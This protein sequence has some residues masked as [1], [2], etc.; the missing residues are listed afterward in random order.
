MFL[1]IVV[2]NLFITQ[3]FAISN[4][5][6]AY[7]K[8][9]KSV[10]WY[11]SFINQM[12]AEKKYYT[13]VYWFKDYIGK[14]RPFSKELDTSL[15]RVILAI[16]ASQFEYL[17]SRYLENSNSATV[18]YIYA[19]KLMKRNRYKEALDQV[20]RIGPRHMLMPFIYHMKG[21]LYSAQ[22]QYDRARINFED[23]VRSSDVSKPREKL[24]KEYCIAGLARNTYGSRNLEKSES[25][26]LDV[27]KSSRVWP[28]ILYEEAWNSYYR[29]KYN[30]TLGKLVTYKAPVLDHMFGPKI[31]V[32]NAI[33]YLKMCLYNDAQQISDQFWNRYQGDYRRLRSLLLSKRNDHYYFYKLIVDFEKSGTTSRS[34]LEN[35]LK[36]ITLDS[37]Y[38]AIRDSFILGADELQVIKGFRSSKLAR[39]LEK[40]L[41]DTLKDQQQIIGAFVRR[42][43]HEHYQDLNEA[44]ES[45]SYIKLE[46]LS[47]RK[48]QLYSFE[49]KRE[50][51]GDVKYLERNAKQYFWDFNGEFWADE[52]GDYVFALKSECR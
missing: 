47:Q 34:Y 19:K 25:Q 48:K 22:K 51:R 52:L 11:R 30:R 44:F 15:A 27:P 23:C 31:E 40:R 39:M 16:G 38:Q 41:E 33:S 17:P 8:R 5:E 24:N 35:L 10:N 43:L 49:D 36:N 37:R 14:G 2:L 13:A 9:S 3:L 50:K 26:Y 7:S 21:V 12:I 28:Q 4:I 20:N 29:G 46:V 1:R 6:D 42:V 32:L 45:M 18:Q